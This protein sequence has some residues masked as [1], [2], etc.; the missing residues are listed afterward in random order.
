MKWRGGVGDNRMRS[1]SLPG[2]KIATIAAVVALG[3]LAGCSDGPQLPRLT[4]LNPFAEKEIPLPGKR[5]PVALSENRAGLDVAPADRPIALPPPTANEAWSQPG[6]TA[7]NTPGHLAL[8]A[9][10]KQIWSA[11][12]GTGS[13]SYGRLTA[14]PIVVDGR[15]ITLDANALVTAFS[16]SGAVVWRAPLTPPN[17]KAYKGF[18]GGLAADGGRIFVGTGF[19]LVHALD[20]QSGKKLWE[21]NLASPIRA[22][23]TAVGDKVVV[24]TTDGVAVALAT[25]DGNELWRHQGVA[26]KAAIL[27]NSS[28]A[29]DND[30][31]VVP[32]PSGDLVALRTSTGQPLWTESLARTRLASSLGSMTDVARPALSSGTVF[33]VG[34][35]GRMVATSARTGERLWSINVPGIQAPNVVGDIVYVVDISGQLLAITRREGKVLWNAK[36]PNAST[37][38][39]PVVAGGRLWLASNKGLVVGV[40]ATAGKVDSQHQIGDATYIAPIVAGGRLYVLTDTARLI[41]FQ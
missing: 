36:L 10:I 40:E 16:S 7:S 9:T 35:S 37:W 1:T 6:G 15:V 5:I 2:R 23:P 32:Y 28:P 33:A 24:V 39:G 17:E 34:H 41:A 26:E 18:G 21:K 31:T 13:S 3:A 22:S 4:D 30:V 8:N 38:S 19:G 29:I 14:S 25:A 12:A 20:A 27:T 11:S